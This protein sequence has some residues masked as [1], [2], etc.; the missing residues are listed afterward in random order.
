MTIPPCT[1]GKHSTVDDTPV[2]E[3]K[4]EPEIPDIKPAASA[5]SALP[6]AIPRLPQA[7]GQTTP[8]PPASPA[9]PEDDSDDPDA[10]VPENASFIASI[11]LKKIDKEA[12]KIAFSSA[13]TV[14]LDLKTADNK[15]YKQQVPTYAGI[16][17]EKSTF[18]VMGT[19]VELTLA[20]ADATSWPVLRSDERVT[21]EIIQMGKAGR[22]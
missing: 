7:Q 5:E 8:K 9:P 21:G 22:V 20:K 16:D 3:K 19:K 14:D 6:A 11:F 12:S 17:P 15:R 4:P 18:K 2:P 13:T 1:T 10:A